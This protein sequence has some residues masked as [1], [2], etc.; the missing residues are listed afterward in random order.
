MMVDKKFR[1][2]KP[3]LILLKELGIAEVVSVEKKL[4]EKFLFDSLS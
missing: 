2:G 3:R 4:I 1:E